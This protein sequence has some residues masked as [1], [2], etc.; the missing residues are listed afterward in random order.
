MTRLYPQNL[1]YVSH[2][3]ITDYEAFQPLT[4]RVKTVLY[5]GYMLVYYIERDCF[6]TY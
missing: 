4:N 1:N 5:H 6:H 2:I 3:M